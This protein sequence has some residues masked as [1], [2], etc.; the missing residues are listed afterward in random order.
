MGRLSKA[1]VAVVAI[2]LLIAGGGIYALASSG[3]GTIT[4]CVSH[5]GGTLYKAHKCAKHDKNLTWSKRGP[6]GSQGAQGPK[7]APGPKGDTGGPGP[8]ASAYAQDQNTFNFVKSSTDTVAVQLTANGGS[9]LT[10]GF[11]AR[12]HVNGV[13]RLRNNTGSGNT[14][15]TGCRPQIRPTAARSPMLGP[16]C[17]D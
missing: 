12:L 8:T 9:P 15:Q 2:A 14:D 13:V 6:A 5:K 11:P 4:V 16:K 1:A 7:G 10:V 17:W 3:G